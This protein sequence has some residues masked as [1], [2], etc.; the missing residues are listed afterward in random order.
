TERP[1]VRIELARQRAV[2]N[3]EPAQTGRIA[4]PIALD[5][6]EHFG[7]EDG[8]LVNAGQVVARE[9]AGRDGGPVRMLGKEYDNELGDSRSGG[10]VRDRI[11]GPHNDLVIASA[12]GAF[13]I[14]PDG[15]AELDSRPFPPGPQPRPGIRVSLTRAVRDLTDRG[16]VAIPRTR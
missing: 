13:V 3:G 2:E 15:R 9:D 10:A 6:A 16:D 8:D 1:P 5:R 11:P 12:H 4:G 7:A 14:E